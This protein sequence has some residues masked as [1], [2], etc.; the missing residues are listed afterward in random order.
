MDVP[1]GFTHRDF[2]TRVFRTGVFRTKD[3]E[4][5]A[6]LKGYQIAEQLYAG[7]RTLVYRGVRESDQCPV[8]IKLLRTAFPS[9]N[10]L[11]QFRNQYTIA[12][13]LTDLIRQ[14]LPQALASV[15]RPLALEAYGNT[16]ALVMEDFGGIS[17]QEL[18]KQVETMGGSPQA[19][20][21]FLQIAI[22]LAIA[23]EGL[24]RH[25]VIH[26][27]LKPANMLIHPDTREIKL[28]DFS[29]ASLLPRETQ[30]IQN[31]NVLEGTLAYLSPEQTGRMNRGIDYRSDFYSLGIVFY[32]LLTGQLPFMSDDPMELVH[33]HLAKPPI[34]IHQVDSRVP[35]AIS[36]IVSKLMAKN[37]EDRY[38]SALG[39]KH[40]LE[41]C[42]HQLQETGT[43][44]PFE[45]AA[46]DFCDRFLIPEKLYG[47]AA[48]VATLLAAFDRASAGSTE[49]MLVAGCSGIG[50]TAIVNEVHKPIA[51]GAQRAN[52]RRA[53]ARQRSY[54]IKGKYDQFQRNILF[55]AFVQAFRD[56]M[57]QL[58]SE[59]D[60][61]LAQWKARF[62]DAVGE[63]GQVLIEVIPELEQ[64]MG[65]QPPAPELSGGAAQ[66]RFNLL[67]QKFVQ[68]FTTAEHPLVIFLDDLQWADLASLKLLQ[69]LLQDAKYLLVIGAYRDN[70]VIPAHPFML[71][72]QEVRQ[73]GITVNTVTLPPLSPIDLNQF[74]ADTLNCATAIA[75]PLTELIYQKTQGNPFFTTQFLKALHGDGLITFERENGSWQCDIPKVRSLAI[76][77]DVVEFMALQLQKL[78]PDTQTG[79]KLAACIGAQFDL[80]TL[81][82]VSEKSPE[83]M[84]L[85]LWQALQV[86][87]V[88]PTTEVYKFF[89]QADTRSDSA[90]VSAQ[91]A[92][93]N[94]THKFLHDRIQQAAY[95][96]IPADQKQITHLK[97]GQLLLLNSP[98]AEQEEKIF[99]IVNQLNLGRSLLTQPAEQTHLMQLNL[100][101]ARKAKASTAYDA[102]IQYLEISIV[103]LPENSWQLQPDLTRQVYEEAT[104]A[105]YLSAN[106]LQMEQL[107]AIALSQND[108]VI[109]QIRVYEI[110]MQAARAQKRLLE[111]LQI[112]LQL[113]QLLE[114]EFPAQPTSAD[115]GQALAQTLRAWQDRSIASLVDEPVMSDPIK[116]V[117]MRILTAMIAPAYQAAPTLLPLLIFKQ[118]NLCL[119]EGNSAISAFS[120]ADY[121]LVLCGV[122]GDLEAGY[123]FGQLALTVLDRFQAKANKCR[124]YLIV[125]NCISHWKES[126][127]GQLPFLQ[128]GYQ[129]GLE[130]GDLEHSALS[131]L[132]Y[133]TYAYFAG[134][135]LPTL[136]IEME[137]YR[138]GIS[139]LKQEHILISQAIYYQTVLNLLGQSVDPCQLEGKIY[140][141]TQMLQILQQSNLRTALYYVYYNK[142]VLCYLLGRYQQ[143]LEYIALVESYAKSITSTFVVTLFCFY[144]SL[145][146]LKVYLSA[147]EAE[148]VQYLD[149]VTANQEKM[150]RWADHAPMN[151]LHKYHL[152]EAERY[153]VAGEKAEA[154]EHYDRA[155]QLAQEN[156][157]IQD[158]ALAHE[159]A[160]QFY[161]DW[162]KEKV[163]QV[164]LID[165]YYAYS[166]WGA[167][168]KVED[169]EQRYP[170]HLAPV[171]QRQQPPFNAT[172]TIL[173]SN[174]SISK[175]ANLA[176]G[177]VS[178]R[179]DLT[180]ILKA[181]Q[182]LSSEMELEKLLS[183][184]LQVVL[185][186]AGADKC[187]LLM[188]KA[189]QWMIEAC[190][191]LGQPEISLQSVAIAD[192]QAV[193]M[194]LINTVQHT[195]QPSII[196]NVADQIDLIADPYIL[197]QSPKSILCLPVLNQGRLIGILYLENN[198][199]IGAFTSDRVELLNL[200][201]VQA[202]ISI[203]NAQLYAREREKAR[204]LQETLAALKESEMQFKQLFEQS[205]DAS[206]MLSSRGFIACNQAAVDLFQY[207]SKEQLCA[208][209]PSD[210]SPKFQ[211]DSDSSF[212]KA[213]QM[214]AKALQKGG[215]QFEW[216]HKRMNEEIF[217]A[218]VLL[219]VIPYGGEKVVHSVV[220]DISDRKQAEAQ[221]CK[222]TE[223][224]EAALQELQ[225][226]QVQLIQHEKMSAL[227]NLVSGVA[228]E[229]NN[230]IGFLDG[231]IQPALDYINDIFGL[232]DLY[233]QKYPV[234]DAE[235]QAEIKTIELDYIREDLPN[236]IGSMQEG[237]KRIREISTSLR[238][239]SR[240]DSDRPVAYNIH[241]GI[242]STLLILKHRL[243]ANEFRPEIQVITDYGDLPLV[244]CFAGQLNQVFMNLLANA[245]D[246]LED[247]NLGQSF[248]EVEANPNQ[249]IIKT[250]RSDNQQQVIIRI[251]D[252][253]VGMSEQVKQ[254]VF[255][256]L[257]TTKSVGQGTG[258]GLA[259][260]HQIV[261]E[262]HVGAIAV[263]STLGQGTEFSIT[264]PI[265]AEH[266]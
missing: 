128:E 92:G 76:T 133:C 221:L 52:T 86:G 229:I 162:G 95:S 140:S 188:P 74:V 36:Q 225:T 57:R 101:A 116:L 156:G 209:H 17:L 257:F 265:C 125:H 211:P 215:H 179:L 174:L 41:T 37:A 148:Q 131:A 228:H 227:G 89:T 259:I 208:V 169:L 49:L 130:T 58:R 159:L 83:V 260:A 243:K 48:E 111:S 149:K 207:P 122:V 13:A 186:N 141:E 145:G 8:V 146:Y 216:M 183:A 233:Q 132:T 166:R 100:T 75:Q 256:H 151:H 84:A 88:I 63:N 202:A 32:E 164:Y 261:V 219:T 117:A 87:L 158:A 232:L 240:A 79:L 230:P 263:T 253:G 85:G 118:I 193:P 192:G 204:T 212:E 43:I 157:Y 40:D 27:D 143:V 46:R 25:R 120:Y 29:I 38:Q 218:D 77:D 121:G 137:I 248:A 266:Q 34:A 3:M 70:E 15:V 106:Y 199:V 135:E 139:Q 69:L 184:L 82:I 98:A 187:M 220:R 96:L 171:L 2:R 26:K 200:F 250:E 161:L 264:L 30:S 73:A 247:S 12:K 182:T 33:C 80:Q 222:K 39:L 10:E 217:W 23:L 56:L 178:E 97:I 66:N 54:F 231:N 236:L 59:S 94:P 115:I 144:S 238:T 113:L 61:Q 190:A 124:T 262:K 105:A 127:N 112:G 189:N 223:A 31:P 147:T 60:A 6:N 245:I 142:L 9:F 170:Q 71:T 197:Q 258:L 1:D 213:N 99:A 214:I 35:I 244:A 72:V 81:A 155:I 103:L 210:I 24:Y 28:I 234:P 254:K 252:N 153:R 239:F 138:Q 47:R 194:P 152:V 235:V 102:A 196:D 109:D 107:I 51:R 168:V 201:C 129:V 21:D 163:A 62:L 180:A 20:S 173:S 7:S 246:A 22:Q 91:Q 203:E 224:L 108:R 11:I 195:L 67:F 251:Q 167:K 42:L 65:Q 5:A 110:K 181:S 226:T 44:A 255:D 50:K 191:Q 126:L 154:I 4:I 175:T 150:K 206:L 53:N 78:P 185:D 198:L 93:A 134:N 104:E 14:D 165:A 205:A 242:D 16:Y 45:L 123:Q 55:S 64:I 19:L 18:L 160:A 241:D 136:A 172:E 177:S 249:I 90:D 176:I 68:L 114:V 237:V 119:T